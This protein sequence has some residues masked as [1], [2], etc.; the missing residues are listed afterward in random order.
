M[1]RKKQ[2]DKV[3]GG[4]PIQTGRHVGPLLKGVPG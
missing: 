2:E 4:A 1:S 3:E